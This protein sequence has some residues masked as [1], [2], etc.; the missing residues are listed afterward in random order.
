MW[1]WIWIW[2][3]TCLGLVSIADHQTGWFS[4]S[5]SKIR[6]KYIHISYLGP[7]K[8]SIYP[9]ICGGY[10]DEW[11]FIG[12]KL[13]WRAITILTHYQFLCRNSKKVIMKLILSPIFFYEISVL[14]WRT[15]AFLTLVSWIKLSKMSQEKCVA[16]CVGLNPTQSS[17]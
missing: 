9:G 17:L 14:F 13:F 11:L 10:V 15:I 6:Y 16:G 5:P 4:F 1:T 8:V 12:Q 7:L 3:W 2:T